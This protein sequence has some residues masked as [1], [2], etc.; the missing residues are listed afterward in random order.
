MA[1]TFT[2]SPASRNDRPRVARVFLRRSQ[3]GG[4]N[5]STG[6]QKHRLKNRFGWRSQAV[7]AAKLLKALLGAKGLEPGPDD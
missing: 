6:A 5:S 4:A 1:D 3:S 2:L 7:K